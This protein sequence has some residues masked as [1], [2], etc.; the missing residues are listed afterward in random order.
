[1]PLQRD[2]VSH[3][4]D[5]AL[6]LAWLSV[7]SGAKTEAVE[8][9]AYGAEAKIGVA[10]GVLDLRYE[11]LPAPPKHGRVHLVSAETPWKTVAT[12]SPHAPLHTDLYHTAAED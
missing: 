7:L 3:M 12:C 6:Q 11:V 10:V 5:I 8:L 4:T 2:V 9:R 1:M